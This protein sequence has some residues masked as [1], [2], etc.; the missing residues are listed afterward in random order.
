MRVF[1]GGYC[2]IQTELII[3]TPT[4]HLN[5]PASPP[6]P[7]KTLSPT[8][9]LPAKKIQKRRCE[10]ELLRDYEDD[11]NQPLP[12]SPPALL[13]TLPMRSPF[14]STPLPPLPDSSAAILTTGSLPAPLESIPASPTID[15]PVPPALPL[16]PPLAATLPEQTAPVL[17]LS[18]A[19][20]LPTSSPPSPTSSTPASPSHALPLPPPP[21][22]PPETMP[23]SPPLP[24]MPYQEGWNLCLHCR[25]HYH[26]RRYFLCW[27]CNFK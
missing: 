18:A 16:S 24:R 3:T 4:S 20:H 10:L 14:P 1:F 6:H 2:S 23:P 15:P 7:A 8:A 19:A 12:I 9:P 27:F 21:A 5:H 25:K 11:P 13:P 26:Q 22:A 17:M